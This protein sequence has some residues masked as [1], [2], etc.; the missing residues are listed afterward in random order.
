MHE[1][2]RQARRLGLALST[3]ELLGQDAKVARDFLRAAR[4]GQ[5]LAFVDK[6]DHTALERVLSAREL[7]VRG[8]S[9]VSV[10]HGA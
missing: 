4:R 6:L 7:R 9:L 1:V 2:E 8:S 3:L 5:G 10:F